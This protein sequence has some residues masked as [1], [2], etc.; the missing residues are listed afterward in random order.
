MKSTFTLTLLIGTVFTIQ[1]A[2][3]STLYEAARADLA[4]ELERSV[5]PDSRPYVGTV[6]EL[7]LQAKYKH[8]VVAHEAVKVIHQ[9]LARIKDTMTDNSAFDRPWT[10]PVTDASAVVC[11]LLVAKGLSER[12]ML[13]HNLTHAATRSLITY[14][15]PKVV[16]SSRAGE[17]VA[18]S[19]RIKAGMARWGYKPAPRESCLETSRSAL[20]SRIGMGYTGPFA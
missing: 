6:G 17:L 20:D 5:S 9:S 10:V 7:E 2:D 16:A 4:D 8:D 19:V 15:K 3:R 1:A 18:K 13:S 12:S 11:D 14:V